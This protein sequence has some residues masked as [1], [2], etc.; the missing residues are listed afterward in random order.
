MIPGLTHWDL[1]SIEKPARYLGGEVNQ[2]APRPDAG[3]RVCLG[4]PDLYELGMSNI[5]LK[6]L[7]AL[8]DADPGIA[9]ERVFAPWPDFE[10]LLRRK[11]LP[12]VSLESKRPLK[13][14]DLVGLTLP[15]EMTFT[16]LLNMLDLGGIPTDRRQRTGLPLVIGGGP[17]GSN[18][19]VLG[20]FFDAILIGDGEEAMPEL[21]GVVRRG[22]TAGTPRQALLEEIAG[23][24]GFWVP[25]VPRPVRRRVF[26]GFG[27]SAPPLKPVVPNIETI[28]DRAPLEIFRGCVQGCRFCNAGF[29]YRP[30]RERPPAAL[31]EWGETLLRQTGS[32]ALGLISLSTSDYSHLPELLQQLNERKAFPDQSLSVPSLRMNE[33]T[34]EML[35]TMPDLR[36]SGLTFAPEAGSQRLRDIINKRITEEDIFKVVVATKDSAYRVLKLYFMIGLPFETDADVDAIADLVRRLDD[37]ARRAKARKEFSISLSG[38]VPKPFTPFQWAGQDPPEV[39]KEKRLRVCAA[40]KKCPAKI[41][42]R[43]EFLC[44]LET[45]LARGDGRVGALLDEARRQGSRFD[46]WNEHFSR[47]SWQRAF[48]ATGL[49]PAEFTRPIPLDRP[50]PWDFIDFRVPRAFLVAEYRRAADLA[51]VSVP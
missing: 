49:D 4:F 5:A 1:L 37:A 3:L 45:V 27:S 43:D 31:A 32:D 25:A 15:Y 23:L 11:G 30:K 38:F 36:K 8:C 12:L 42:W 46:G 50:L 21:C 13:D 35:S 9:V 16:N 44:Q 22:K 34:L 18:P 2:A 7:Y 41:S 24:E 6:I 14:F 17:S 10:A 47:E 20:D 39:L 48:A 19:V 26:L 29:Y 40:L 51:G 28:H 33:N